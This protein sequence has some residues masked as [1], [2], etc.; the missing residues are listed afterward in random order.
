MNIEHISIIALLF[1]M[2]DDGKILRYDPEDSTWGVA[3]TTPATPS[4]SSSLNLLGFREYT[5]SGMFD[6]FLEA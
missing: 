6:R 3:F 5:H 1:F 4:G 2:E